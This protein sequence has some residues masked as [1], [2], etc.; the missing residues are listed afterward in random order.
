MHTK[1]SAMPDL[2]MW[3]L[4]L[5]NDLY[6]R[7]SQKVSSFLKCPQC[8]SSLYFT[9]LSYRRLRGGGEKENTNTLRAEFLMRDTAGEEIEQAKDLD[10]CADAS[11]RL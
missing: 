7:E 6:D 5:P 3:Y 8:I 2:N 1:A 10:L 9:Y 11:L 4:S